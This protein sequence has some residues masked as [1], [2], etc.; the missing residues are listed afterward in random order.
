MWL[1]YISKISS[2]IHD[3]KTKFTYAGAWETIGLSIIVIFLELFLLIVSLPVYI[4]IAPEKFS[5]N[6]KEVEKY[7][8]KRKFS[9]IGVVGFI[10]LLLIKTTLFSGLFFSNPIKVS[11]L[12]LNWDFNNSAEYVFDSSRIKIKDGMAIYNFQ[13]KNSTNVKM[14]LSS[15]HPVNSLKASNI[16]RWTG[17]TENADKKSGNIYYQLSDDNGQTWYYWNGSAWSEAGEQNYNG[18]ATINNQIKKFPPEKGQIKFKAFFN[19]NFPEQ[20]KLIDIGFAYDSIAPNDYG[21]IQN[22]SKN[23]IWLYHDFGNNYWIF[24]IREASSAIAIDSD[25]QC[26]KYEGEVRK[27]SSGD[28]ALLISIKALAGK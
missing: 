9:L 11:A 22:Y 4:F 21:F 19:N 10:L 27:C 5:K 28:Y 3:F 1:N 13:T 15:I 14:S 7:R 8:L 23:N 16:I 25:G 12:S 26:V 17:F 18:A 6:K 20:I 2:L 24:G